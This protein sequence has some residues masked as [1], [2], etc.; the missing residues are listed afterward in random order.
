[1][2]ALRDLFSG[3]RGFFPMNEVWQYF[4]EQ[5]N[6][7][8]NGG[9]PSISGSP[10][11]NLLVDLSHQGLSRVSGKDAAGF[12]QGQ[13]TNDI[14]ALAEGQSQLTA[15]CSVQGKT[16]AILRILRW[17]ECF[18]LGH[19]P[20]ELTELIQKRLQPYILRADVLIEDCGDEYSCLGVSGPR[21][22]RILGLSLP[23][24]LPT[25]PG[26]AV[27]RGTGVLMRMPG[28][29]PRFTLW[30]QTP[31]LMPRWKMLAEHLQLAGGHRWRLLDILGGLPAPG[32]ETTDRFVPQMLNLDALDAISFN[33]GCYTGQEIVARA[34]H[35]GT[36]KR[37][38]YLAEIKSTRL[39]APGESL[40]SSDGNSIGQVLNAEREG[41]E[42]NLMLAV[43]RTAAT[44]Q[45]LHIKGPEG[46]LL[47]LGTLPYILPE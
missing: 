2:K 23:G 43:I 1:M 21:A 42:R 6:I 34:Q 15:L 5:Q 35:R 14:E 16:L 19:F 27:S 17:H 29:A 26:E 11:K 37:R 7:G 4:I 20:R 33:K 24:P 36:V 41:A 32:I 30:D 12:L 47:K 13:T 44:S 28:A 8:R 46:V 38:T 3:W 39:P 9:E 10:E 18:Y 31:A 40:Y 22:E 45:S 25:A